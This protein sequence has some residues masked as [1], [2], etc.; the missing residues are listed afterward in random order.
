[1]YWHEKKKRSFDTGGQVSPCLYNLEITG[2][3]D[4]T[5]TCAIKLN[6]SLDRCKWLVVDPV[7]VSVLSGGASHLFMLVSRGIS[8]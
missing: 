3:K 8:P 6:V 7:P 5:L 4:V 1:M 2:D